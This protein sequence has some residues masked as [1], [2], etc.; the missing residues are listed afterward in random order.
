MQRYHIESSLLQTRVVSCNTVCSLQPP[1]LD[2]VNSESADSKQSGQQIQSSLSPFQSV[3]LG[4]V[5]RKRV[6]SKDS[7]SPMFLTD[8]GQEMRWKQTKKISKSEH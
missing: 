4:I 3:F 7:N 2:E 5:R 8:V 1:L 6:G